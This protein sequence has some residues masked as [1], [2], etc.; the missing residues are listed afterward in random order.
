MQRHDQI[1]E[2]LKKTIQIL[3][4]M[5]Y[6]CKR[7]DAGHIY[8]TFNEGALAEE[9]GITTDKFMGR[10]FEELVPKKILSTFIP[11]IQKVFM[12]ENIE[13]ILE[14]EDRVFN[15]FAK[16][17]FDHRPGYEINVVEVVGFITDITE[18]KK[19][20]DRLRENEEQ[21]RTLINSM[22]DFVFLK[23]GEGRW[24]E[25]NEIALSFFQLEGIEYSGKTDSELA[26]F[27]E[28]Y[29]DAL[30]GCA[31]SD[32]LAWQAKAPTR[33]EENIPRPDGSIR[34]FD[35][36]KV[37]IFYSCGKRKGL[38]VIGRDITERK[39]AEEAL[40]KAETLSIVSQL[41]AGVAHEIRNPLTALK[42][43]VQLLQKKSI[44]NSEYYD[45]MLSEVDRIDFIISEFLVLS[46]PQSVSYQRTNL[47]TLLNNTITL[48][49][50][51]AILNNVQIFIQ[52][53]DE[54]PMIHCEQNQLKQ[55]FINLLKNATEAMPDGGEIQIDVARSEEEHV[56]IRF[57]DQGYGIPEDRLPSLGQP[58]YTTKEKGTG[59]GLMVSYKIIKDH[60]GSIKVNSKVN[61]GTCFE[62]IL[63]IVKD[64]LE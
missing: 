57:T 54:L 38:V 16:P 17:I 61:E 18:Q 29:F 39:K 48:F 1:A 56:I 45:I 5:V 64:E 19:D 6:K 40:R 42:G 59:L 10:S 46:K 55:V 34:S 63:P 26:S 30:K 3:P 4:N 44:E 41:A 27:S 49:D 2:E 50:T 31:E 9:F 36:I 13:F 14:F 37:P 62:V 53:E 22:P 8:L 52:C 32:E 15:S 11:S 23:D 28:F 24:L 20:A 35:V 58:F 51:Q 21:L 43:F 12:G 25:T 60:K 47:E 7:D 33:I